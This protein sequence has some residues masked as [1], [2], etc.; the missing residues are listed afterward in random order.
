MVRVLLKPLKQNEHID[1]GKLEHVSTYFILKT[2]IPEPDVREI[3]T[4]FLCYDYAQPLVDK[5]I[6]F[7]D[8]CYIP[9]VFSF[10]EHALPFVK[11][12]LHE[13]PTDELVYR[14]GPYCA[15]NNAL[16]PVFP[17]ESHNVTLKNFYPHND[18]SF[19][20]VIFSFNDNSS[21]RDYCCYLP[22]YD[23]DSNSVNSKTSR[24]KKSVPRTISLYGLATNV[25]V[26]D[27][28]LE[29][30]T[31]NLSRLHSNSAEKILSNAE[32]LKNTINQDTKNEN[33]VIVTEFNASVRAVLRLRSRVLEVKHL[34][35]FSQEIL[36]M[37]VI[38]SFG[39]SSADR[40][41]IKLYVNELKTDC[42]PVQ[43]DMID[44]EFLL[45][46]TLIDEEGNGQ[47]QTDVEGSFI[48]V[49]Q[50]I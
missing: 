49:S 41:K 35:F 17:G 38:L 33:D 34:T 29:A 9:R 26:L 24:K 20:E 5:G 15:V 18:D 16:L 42:Q 30:I 37:T 13:T 46:G 11:F 47:S 22:Y 36:C 32:I 25:R 1:Y 6:Y 8:C 43:G 2:L 44:A 31:E 48:A 10:D 40:R 23:V 4:E 19:G 3:T 7:D 39:A 21:S 50:T 45:M 28:H 12:E 14:Q 27:K